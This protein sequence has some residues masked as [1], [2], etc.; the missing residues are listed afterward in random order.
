MPSTCIFF[1][2]PFCPLSSISNS[3]TFSREAP[4]CRSLSSQLTSEIGRPAPPAFPVHASAHAQ[5]SIQ[6]DLTPS[7]LHQAVPAGMAWVLAVFKRSKLFSGRSVL[8]TEQ[9]QRTSLLCLLWSPY[10]SPLRPRKNFLR[11]ELE[12]ISLATRLVHDDTTSCTM[13]SSCFATVIAPLLSVRPRQQEISAFQPRDMHKRRTISLATR[14]IPRPTP[15]CTVFS[16]FVANVITSS[17]IFET[18]STRSFQGD[19]VRTVTFRR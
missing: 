13:F 11:S 4:P 3:L 19:F 5:R 10:T 15:S 18:T 12:T 8:Q 7:L 9:A 16:R 2:S 17:K 1:L 6:P 14:L